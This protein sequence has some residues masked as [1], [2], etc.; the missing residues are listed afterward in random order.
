MGTVSGLAAFSSPY[1]GAYGWESE[2]IGPDKT[3]IIS[4]IIGVS[5]SAILWLFVRDPRF[6]SKKKTDPS[7]SS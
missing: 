7:N 6:E 3:L 2:I 4:S 5:S 1:I